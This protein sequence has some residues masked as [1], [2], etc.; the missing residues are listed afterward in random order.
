MHWLI[1]IV[2]RYFI[3]FISFLW[4]P[5]YLN[6]KLL[7]KMIYVGGPSPSGGPQKHN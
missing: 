5:I 2:C 7:T 4:N 3:L 1:I 6:N